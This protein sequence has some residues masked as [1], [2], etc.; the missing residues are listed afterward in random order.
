[1][2]LLQWERIN[3]EVHLINQQ[4]HQ[5]SIPEKVYQLVKL[6]E[7]WKFSKIISITKST[8]KEYNI[9]ESHNY[10]RVKPKK[11]CFSELFIKN[12]NLIKEGL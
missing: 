9:R 1:M 2:Q 6:I 5:Q 10:K 8:N 11:R 7:D 3:L 12:K 4:M